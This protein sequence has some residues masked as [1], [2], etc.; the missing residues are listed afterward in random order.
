[1]KEEGNT[2]FKAAKYQQ[3]RDK[4][5]EALEI[6]PT[7]KGTNSKILQNRAMCLTKVGALPSKAWRI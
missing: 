5:T 1:M 2:L 3:A 6:D 7:N 4:Y